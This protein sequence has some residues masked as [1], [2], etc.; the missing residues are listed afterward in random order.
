MWV[1]VICACSEGHMTKIS[2]CKAHALPILFICTLMA[3]QVEPK[4]EETDTYKAL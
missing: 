2:Q 1:L 4:E 3:M